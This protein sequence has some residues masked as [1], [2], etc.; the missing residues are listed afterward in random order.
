MRLVLPTVLTAVVLGVIA[1]LSVLFHQALLAPSLASAARLLVGIVLVT[2]L[3]EA[4]R[5]LILQAE[6]HRGC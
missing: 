5:R 3:G 2:A 4:A 6:R 1:A